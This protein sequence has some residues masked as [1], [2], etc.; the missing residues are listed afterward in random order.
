MELTMP[1]KTK[2]KLLLLDG[3]ISQMLSENISPEK[4][5]ILLEKEIG[6]KVKLSQYCK[7]LSL[8]Y[9]EE[10]SKMQTNNILLTLTPLLKYYE[11]QSL[12]TSI[13][14]KR[15]LDTKLIRIFEDTFIEKKELN[16]FIQKNIKNTEGLN[17]E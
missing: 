10:Y 16:L 3:K 6:K 9:P 17:H 1:R 5:I 15:L 13:I 14:Y 7:Y 11:T 4:Q 8:G 12:K 2:Y